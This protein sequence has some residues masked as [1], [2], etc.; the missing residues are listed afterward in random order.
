MGTWRR[1]KQLEAMTA[2]MEGFWADSGEATIVVGS[3]CDWMTTG[4]FGSDW[5][6][7]RTSEEE[8]RLPRVFMVSAGRIF[9]EDARLRL[10]GGTAKDIARLGI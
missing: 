8:R 4:V 6:V 3:K 10:G 2:N 5:R 1:S 9:V 7:G